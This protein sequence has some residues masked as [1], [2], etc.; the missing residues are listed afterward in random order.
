MSP[1]ASGGMD[2]VL[3]RVTAVLVEPQSPGN[4]GSA[5]RALHNM[6]LSRLRLVRPVEFRVAEARRM[7]MG[8]Q[9]LLRDAGESPSLP[10]AIAEAGLVI[11]TTRRRGKNREPSLD[12]RDAAGRAASAA[13]SGDEVAL[14]F[15]REDSGLTTAELDACHLLAWIPTGPEYPSLNLNSPDRDRPE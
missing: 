8:G 12:V 10:A 2:E 15:G 3:R 13:A 4:I 11:G 14:V 7:A 6:G 5:A 1:A 9:T